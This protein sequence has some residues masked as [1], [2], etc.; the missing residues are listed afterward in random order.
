MDQKTFHVLTPFTVKALTTPP[1]DKETVDTGDNEIIKIS[2]YANFSGLVEEGDVFIDLVGDVVVPSGIDVSVWKKN[3]QV[4]LHHMRD[5]TVG[6]GLT[7]V[8]KKDGLFI[9]AEIH[10]GAMQEEDFYRVKSGLLCFFSIGFRTMAG[11]YKKVGD[12]QV[13]FITKS[14]LLEV[15]VVGIP[16]NGE[17]AFRV[18]KSLNDQEGFYAGDLSEKISPQIEIENHNEEEQG[19]AMKVKHRELLPASVVKELEERGMSAELDTEKELSFAELV[20]HIKAV[21]LAEIKA[22]AEQKAAEEA[23]AAQE[24]ADRLAAEAEQKA[25]QEEADRLAAEAEQKAAEEAVEETEEDGEF[26]PT[27]ALK[28]LEEFLAAARKE[29]EAE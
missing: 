19:D 29:I 25:A 8:K 15:S 14:L 4:L 27:D 20:A 26:D 9:E 23:K 18:V 1:H 22:E 21:V 24:E 17:S 12:R 11:E 13:Y 28:S 7:V 6:R 5:C 2:G 3:P 10:K 16:A